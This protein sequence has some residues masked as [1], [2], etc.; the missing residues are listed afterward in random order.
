MLKD[1]KLNIIISLVIAIGLWAYV[2]G[3]INP[4]DSR[5]FRNIPIT[6]LNTQV[7]EDQNL[8][9]LSASVESLNVEIYGTRTAIN[10]THVNDIVATVDLADAEKGNNDL[11][12]NVI[13]PDNVELEN[14]S[15]NKITVVVEDKI[16]KEVD[17]R[18]GYSGE[19]DND[20]EALTLE[21]SHKTTTVSGAESQVEK[22]M[23]ANA[24]VSADRVKSNLRT[25]RAKI[26]PVDKDGIEV[27][28]V[29]ATNE[30][31]KVTTVLAKTKTVPL[32]VVIRDDSDGTVERKVSAPKYITIKGT[33][34]VIDTIDAVNSQEI[35][36]TNILENT[37]VEIVP[38]L[39]DGVQISDRSQAMAAVI[40]VESIFSKTFTFKT[41][42]IELIGLS[43]SL[44]SKFD[45]EKVEL[46]ITGKKAIIDDLTMDDIRLSIDLAKLEAGVHQVAIKAEC[47][48]E[49][50]E[51]VIKPAKIKV[52]IE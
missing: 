29:T 47:S 25:V 38:I 34:S 4:Q 5:M 9:V 27:E 19:F 16:T 11:I 26:V 45:A 13:I 18:V 48:K 8:A 6:F 43:D 41:D 32:N 37:T 14:K 3:E 51:I 15:L 20:T 23:Y 30:I 39:P 42:D 2:I 12:V 28:N 22:V 44:T 7:L 35:D 46:T 52:T 10:E 17:I 36:I 50:A 1:K 24:T 31:V 40:K 33:K 21:T 49:Y